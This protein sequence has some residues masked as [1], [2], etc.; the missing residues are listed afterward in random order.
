MLPLSTKNYED[1]DQLMGICSL[2]K[3]EVIATVDACMAQQTQRRDIIAI[4]MSAAHEHMMAVLQYFW[5][6][7]CTQISAFDT[8]SMVDWCYQYIN[9]LKKFG[10]NDHHLKNGY[11]NLC[12]AYS[13]KVHSQINPLVVVVIEQEMDYKNSVFEGEADGVLNTRAPNDLI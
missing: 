7:H 4:Y 9:E 2:I 6:K 10:I 1:V 13:R 5:D 11:I 12:E 3:E 8:L